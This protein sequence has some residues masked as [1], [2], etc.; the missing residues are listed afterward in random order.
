MLAIGCLGLASESLAITRNKAGIADLKKGRFAEAVAE[1]KE[2]SA[3]EPRSALFRNN[4]GSAYLE[5]GLLDEAVGAFKEAISIDPSKASAHKYLADAYLAQGRL[6]EA[7]N[8]FRTALQ[9]DPVEAAARGVYS[10]LV[11]LAYEKGNMDEIYL[12]LETLVKKADPDSAKGVNG[13][14]LPEQAILHGYHLQGRYDEILDRTTKDIDVLN[15]VVTQKAGVVIPIPLPFII[16]FKRVGAKHFNVTPILAGMYNTRAM[17]YLNKGMVDLAI[18]D[19]AQS[20]EIAPTGPGGLG[21]GLARLESGKVMEASYNLRQ[22]LDAH[23]NQVPVH[24]YY[25]VALHLCGDIPGGEEAIKGAKE[26]LGSVNTSLK[27][28]FEVVQAQ[29]MVDQT[30][31]RFDEALIEYGRVVAACP[32]CGLAFRNMGEI[33]LKRDEKVKASNYLQKAASLMPGDE[34][35][36]LLLAQAQVGTAQPY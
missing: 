32:T 19:F 28:N 36:R 29:A 20:L 18:K 17:A 7:A 1:F 10:G 6:A 12:E 26:R 31:G 21:A 14:F 30:W 9:V 22:C 23:P 8:E 35:A 5:E 15:G 34:R 27:F 16:L 13:L 11:N 4:V 24:F 2:A 25:A 33:L 3:L